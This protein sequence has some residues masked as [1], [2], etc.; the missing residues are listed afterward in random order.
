MLRYQS[1]NQNFLFTFIFQREDGIILA[2]FF[3]KKKAM[4]Y[5]RQV[6][7]VHEFAC[8][9]L[10]DGQLKDIL[11]KDCEQAEKYAVLKEI[12]F[13]KTG[14]SL[15]DTQLATAFSMKGGK[16]A[17][18]PTGEGKT[19]AAVVAAAC[20]ALEGRR[21]HILVF[22]DYLAKRDWQ[23]NKDIYEFCGLTSG[24]IDQHSSTKER[25]KAY[26]SNITYIS[27][28]EAGFDF[29]RDFLCM[30][31][32]ELVFPGFDVAIVD[33]ADSI[34]ID[35]SKTP[36]VLAGEQSFDMKDVYRVNEA[37]LTLAKKD[38]DIDRAEQRVWLTDSGYDHMEELLGEKFGEDENMDLA[39]EVQSSLEA[40]YLVEKDKDY[41]IKDE[42]IRIIEPST[43]R[44]VLNKR[45]PDLLHRA[46]EVKEG[47]RLAP[48]TL[49]FNSMSMQDFL[50]Q[51]ET[52][53]GMT[54]TIASSKDEIYD[55]FEL[56]VDIIPPNSPCI[57]KDHPDIVALTKKE[58]REAVINQVIACHERQQPVLMGTSSVAES[59]EFSALMTRHRIPHVVLN[60]KNDE[61]EARLIARAGAAGAVTI[62]TN[63]AGRGVDIRLGGEREVERDIVVAAGGLYVL[64]TGINPS[65]RIDNQL[66]GRSGR[67]GDPGE[68][69][70]FISMEDE[71]FESRVADYQLR[72]AAKKPKQL[73]E[74]VR[75][76]QSELDGEAAEARYM[77]QRYA[78]ILE[79]Q[80]EIVSSWRTRILKGEQEADFLQRSEP[81]FYKS[82]CEQ[83]GEQGLVAAQRKLTLFYINKHWADY[84]ATMEAA[85]SGIHFAVLSR[86]SP[87]DEYHHTA[88]NAYDEMMLDIEENVVHAMKTLPITK[89]GVDLDTE[90]FHGGTTTWTYMV[91][92]RLY[93]FSRLPHLINK[94]KGSKKKHEWEN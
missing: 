69:R 24:Y 25:Q 14:L 39:A 80:R 73:E 59:E 58:H 30:E 9:K 67:Q 19:L 33:E 31:E 62:S 26:S 61:A 22:N 49:V 89:D 91:D 93:Q 1:L 65:M 36:L 78:F 32:D 29:L 60:A 84:L 45:Y 41:I 6:K 42:A 15:F 27:A 4:P 47:L 23:D 20:F 17:E 94:V 46:V 66:R 71:I 76:V 87:I 83:A 5:E 90:L 3:R 77:L 37:V 92:E 11:N 34:L 51:Y 86:R 48:Q 70:F 7:G 53:C 74:I 63:M 8:D 12:I 38:I 75:R 85:R 13:R 2:L 43:G 35:E 82:L 68:S 81:D 64:G 28:K 21:V 40:H 52:L 72:K 79:H 57:R 88:I 56:D 44:V 54:G 16:I 50:Q 55:S 18:L 10:S